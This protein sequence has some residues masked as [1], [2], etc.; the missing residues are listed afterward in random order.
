MD[1]NQQSA[2]TKSVPQSSVQ[3]CGDS[4][5]AISSTHTFRTAAPLHAL[6]AVTSDPSLHR[7]CPAVPRLAATTSLQHDGNTT[8]ALRLQPP[9]AAHKRQYREREDAA[10][11]QQPA[12]QQLQHQRAELQHTAAAPAA[13]LLASAI[14]AG[15]CRSCR[16]PRVSSS[17][18]A[19]GSSAR[20]VSG[21]VGVHSQHRCWCATGRKRDARS[22]AGTSTDMTAALLVMESLLN[23]RAPA[24]QRAGK[25]T[26]QQD[27]PVH[28]NYKRY[29]GYRWGGAGG[30]DPRLQVRLVT[31]PV[32]IQADVAPAPQHS[33]AAC[34]SDD[35]Y[36]GLIPDGVLARPRSWGAAGLPASG[37]WTWAATRAWSAWRSPRASAPPRCWASTS[38][39]AWCSAR[40]PTCAGA[41]GV[42]GCG[43][44][45]GPLV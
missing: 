29:Y 23:A 5:S 22:G 33:T 19:T 28:G 42:H 17:A 12:S 8:E 18:T 13:A 38:T 27:I 1:W 9:R 24:A 43:C 35:M 4:G 26:A 3:S 39:Q 32:C 20:A 40:A 6:P 10:A 7:A 25:P 21:I 14:D 16:S 41:C 34:K 36:L 44:H 31:L 30:E 11:Q 2:A 37:A 45:V 15:M